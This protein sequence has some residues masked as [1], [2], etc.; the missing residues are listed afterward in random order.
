MIMFAL[1][2][3]A[4]YEQRTSHN[5]RTLWGVLDTTT[6]KSFKAVSK[7]SKSR[8]VRGL[9]VFVFGLL[10]QGCL[11]VRHSGPIFS[12]WLHPTLLGC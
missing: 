1:I 5:V 2:L 6:W 4:F 12:H 3:E 10:V 7:W 9:L 8:E 11:R